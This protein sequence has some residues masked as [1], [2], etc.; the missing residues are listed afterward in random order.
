MILK[1]G[2]V[3][4][5]TSFYP[6]RKE[7]WH[8]VYSMGKSVV[9]MAVGFLIQ[10]GKLSLDTK[11]VD[12]LKREVNL[13]ALLKRKNLTVEHLLT[14]TSG[15]SFNETGAVSG[16]DWVKSFLESSTHH[17]PGEVFEYNSMNTYICLLYTS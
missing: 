9:S 5:E 15:V 8:A 10:E 7:L 11:I 14:M 1:N 13:I 4:G 12:I 3:I 17:E 16:D 2:K 6:Y